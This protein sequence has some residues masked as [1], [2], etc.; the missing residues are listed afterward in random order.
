MLYG[1]VSIKASKKVS[2]CSALTEAQKVGEQPWYRRNG[3]RAF[4]NSRPLLF[5]Q[6]LENRHLDM[7]L[8]QGHFLGLRGHGGRGWG[9]KLSARAG[10]EWGQALSGCGESGRTKERASMGWWDRLKAQHLS[11]DEEGGRGGIGEW[12]GI[13][14]NMKCKTNVNVPWLD[15]YSRFFIRESKKRFVNTDTFLSSDG[16]WRFCENYLALRGGE[17]EYIM[18]WWVTL[19]PASKISFSTATKAYKEI[20]VGMLWLLIL[21]RYAYFLL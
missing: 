19:H 2:F 7:L 12:H 4:C 20:T 5:Q 21:L 13:S 10:V 8:L 1:S 16:G 11:P 15:K 14:P 17:R 18:T 6:K 9:T 3:L